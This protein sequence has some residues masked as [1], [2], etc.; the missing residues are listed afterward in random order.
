MIRIALLAL[1]WSAHVATATLAAE[2]PLVGDLLVNPSSIELGHVRHPHSII[3]TG[4]SELGQTIDYTAKAKYTSSNDKIARVR[5]DGWIEA[6]ADGEAEIRIE[7]GGKK[8]VA[9]VKVALPK[10]PR[11][12]SFR[13]DVM[14]ALSKAQCNQGACHGYSLGKNGFKL[15]LRGADPD[16]DFLALTDE[17]YERRINRHHPAASLLITKP[18]GDVPHKGGVRITR[19]GLLHELMIGWV[20][21]GAPAEPK[22]SP[23][24]EMLSIYP[25]KIVMRPGW[26]QQLQ[27]IA[28]YSDGSTRDVTRLSLFSVNAERIASVSDDGLVHADQLGETA[29]SARFERTFATAE[30][31]VLNPDAKFQPTPVPANNLIDKFVAIKLNALNITPSELA[32]DE[33]YLRRIYLDL[34]GIQPTPDELLAFAADKNAAKRTEIIERLFQRAEFVD[35]WSLKWGDL[36]QNSRVRLS[37]PAVYAFREWIRGA[38]ESNMPLDEFVRQVVLGQGG[39]SDSPTA[40]F[41]VVSQDT[42]DTLQR[43]TQVFCGVRMLCA[44][45]HAHPFENWTQADYFGLYNFFN[46]VSTKNDPRVVGDRNAKTV[47]L[48]YAAGYEANPR[49][50]RAQPPRYLGGDEPTLDKGVDRRVA[51]AEW[52]TSPGNEFFAR[53]MTNRVWSYFFHRGIIDPVDDLRSTNPPINPDLLD[54]LTKDFIEHRFDVR[55]LMR[56]IVTSQAY[57][58]S[59]KPNSSNAHDD[60]NFSRFVPRR[61]SAESL[62][63]S[64][65]QATGVAEAFP[66]APNGFTARQLPDANIQSEFLKLFGKPQRMEACECERDTG[67]NMLQ[68]LYFINGG[69]IL[70]RIASPQSRIASLVKQHTDDR[71][72]IEQ[73]YLWT[74]CRRPSDQE[75][76]LA[77]ELFAEYKDKR[78]DAAQDFAWALLNSRDFT[79]V[80]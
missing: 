21:A 56:V 31:I 8:S 30:F 79:L 54:G 49:T 46:Q 10:Q 63:D 38:V 40:A 12:F 26:K 80:Q 14:P 57:Q 45:C 74:I 16:A 59:S 53:S 39:P 28:T 22:E 4:R 75:Q 44:K 34:I 24:F 58:R 15:S 42:H 1:A 9:K 76:A 68:A 61:V 18:L 65:V 33:A 43:T 64:I 48:N 47:L 41:Y 2:P 37:E 69:S 32:S 78:L 13:H 19:D 29:V 36:L 60:M 66:G 7:A 5:A 51:Y 70:G 50:G 77:K 17:F 67:S 55:H 27:A 62:L 52:L 11:E 23:T 71:A 73:L 3:V 25:E 6:V 35:Q 72:L 20:G